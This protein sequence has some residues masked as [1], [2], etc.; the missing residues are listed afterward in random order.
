MAKKKKKKKDYTKGWDKAKDYSNRE[1]LHGIVSK[2]NYD[3]LQSINKGTLKHLGKE[4]DDNIIYNARKFWRKHES[5]KKAM[6][7]GK[8]KAVI[9]IGSGQSL[10]RNIEA[11]KFYTQND[12]LLNWNSRSFITIAANHQYKPLLEIGIIPDF[13]LLV[14]ASDVVYDQLCKD[15][16]ASGQNTTLIT[17]LHASPK[18]VEEWTK[19][20]RHI[21]F[22]ITA[23]PVLMS[24]F[25]KETG[26]NPSLHKIELGGN[27][28]NGAFMTAITKFGSTVFFGVGNDL[29]FPIK[30]TIEEQRDLYYADGDYSS[31]AK[32]TGTGRDEAATKKKWAGFSI[33]RSQIINPKGLDRYNIKLDIVGSNATLWVY[34]VWLETTIL[35]QLDKE[36]HFHYFNCSEG[37]ILGVMARDDSDI[38]LTNPTNWYMLDEVAINKHTGSGMYHTAMLEDALPHFIEVRRN[39]LCQ[40]QWS[41]APAA[42]VLAPPRTKDIAN[43]AAPSDLIK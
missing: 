23:S 37:G 27:V 43:F 1:E 11:L 6:G 36:T 21:L 28:L 4:W 24:T 33:E 42:G 30:D 5:L 29:S 8:N 41:D 12:G 10:N 3:F 26:K 18:V 38:A 32:G 40:Y 14:D 39:F 2:K 7:L 9:G 31:N 20:K 15:I 22:Y 25:K 35:S 17:G 34:K 19:Q 13:V 16:P